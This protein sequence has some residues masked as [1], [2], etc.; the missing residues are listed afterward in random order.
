ME[1]AAHQVN[2]HV[3]LKAEAG[4]MMTTHEAPDLCQNK[5]EHMFILLSNIYVFIEIPSEFLY[6]VQI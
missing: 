4:H 2:A 6:K 1:R 5:H 3:T